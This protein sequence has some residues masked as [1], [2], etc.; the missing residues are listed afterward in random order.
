MS[1]FRARYAAESGRFRWRERVTGGEEVQE[2]RH[3]SVG[4]AI[5]A[6]HIT[7]S[8]C[9]RRAEAGTT[10]GAVLEHSEGGQPCGP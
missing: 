7:Q 9:R 2:L 4:W 1:S 5:H 10:V 8:T 6:L 3:R